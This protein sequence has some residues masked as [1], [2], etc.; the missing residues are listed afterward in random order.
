MS[1]RDLSIAW[2]EEHALHRAP[3][4]LPDEIPD[5]ILHTLRRLNLAISVPGGLTVV[6]SP[7]DEPGDVLRAVTWPI[8]EALTRLYAPAVVERDSAV[9]LYLGKTDPAPEIRIR[10]TGGSRW[11]EEIAPGVM[12]RVE[13]GEVGD[14]QSIEVG[15]AVIPVDPPET[16]LL[17]L[18]L[19]FL[20]EG[21]D[22]VA[23][24]LKSLVLARPALTSAYRRQ[25]RPVV[26]KRMEHLARDVGNVRLADLIGQVVA[27]EQTVRIGRDRTGV[28]RDLVV[29]PLIALT[30]S[31][32]QPWLDSLRVAI[33]RSREEVAAVLEG[34]D[35]TLPSRSLDDLLREARE[36]KAYD[37]YHSSSIEGY[38]LSL[39]EVT[40]LLGAS[41]TGE[42]GLADIRS[43]LA[44]IGYGIAF[45]NLLERM[46]HAGGPVRLDAALTLD[47]YMDLF[48]P[49]VEA[50]VVRSEDLR[51]WRTNPVFIRDTLFVPPNHQKIQRM[52]DV[53]FQE[54]EAID[55]SEGTLRGIL[56]HLWLVW[57]HPFPD[58]NGRVARFLMNTAF[59][60]GA[61]PWL[62]IRVEQR[63]PYFG[64]LRRAQLD[65]EYRSPGSFSLRSVPRTRRPRQPYPSRVRANSTR[66]KGLV[67]AGRP[68][69]SMK[70]STSSSRIPPVMK[71]VRSRRS[72]ATRARQS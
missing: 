1:E 26:L 21:L 18:P 14:S 64:A 43:E 60:G 17:M 39:E 30:E 46:R 65:E 72:G 48:T 52:I 3:V 70:R 68:V 16:V 24:W 58:G 20:R 37:A 36:T 56:A 5:Q 19:S 55:E 28:G 7:G 11:R 15:E 25:P 34:A 13:R 8:V 9:R 41:G 23:V 40:L 12:V 6:R 67:M 62:T 63:A 2:I 33:R 29:P 51:G 71:S 42:T 38:R 22:D 50:G 49:S 35:P 44:I 31:T 59:L 10:Q 32:R 47:L 27:E 45:D 57:I 61:V 69:A 54:L 53:L 66:S 4:F